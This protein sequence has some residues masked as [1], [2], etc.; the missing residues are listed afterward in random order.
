LCETLCDFVF[1]F[2]V[3]EGDN[4]DARVEESQNDVALQ[5][6]DDCHPMV[7]GDEDSFGH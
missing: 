4:F 5:E 7:S 6:V 2:V 3:G 1:G